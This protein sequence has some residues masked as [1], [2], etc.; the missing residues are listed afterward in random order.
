MMVIIFES[1]LVYLI[2]TVPRATL[3]FFAGGLNHFYS[4]HCVSSTFCN[5]DRQ[6]DHAQLPNMMRQMLASVLP[7]GWTREPSAPVRSL[8]PHPVPNYLN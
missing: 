4:T 8:K 6:V 7:F 1:Y 2:F 3:P 5:I